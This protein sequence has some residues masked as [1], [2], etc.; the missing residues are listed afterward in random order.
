MSDRHA[1]DMFLS[2]EREENMTIAETTS[3]KVSGKQE[4][5]C[6]VFLGIPFA[7][8]PIG[9]L[10][11][12][13]PIP[14]DPWDGVR[15]CVSF[16]S[17]SPQPGNPTFAD[18]RV[19]MDEDCLTLNVFTPACDGKKRPVAIW[20]H[21][22][23][24][25]T[26]SA[27]ETGLFPHQICVEQDV[28]N[29][30]IQYRLGALGCV[31]F[32]RLSGSG[33][34]FDANCGTWDQVM[35]VEWVIAN[36]ENFGGDPKN[37][38]LMGGSAGGTSVLTLITTPYLKGKIRRA[39]MESTSFYMGLTEENG[40]LA[41]LSVLNELGLKE[42]EVQK[43]LDIPAD[44]LAQAANDAEYKYLSYRPYTIPTGPV[45]DGDLVPEL[46]FDALMRGAADGIDVL[47][48]STADEGSLFTNTKLGLPLLFPVR[49]EDLNKF[50]ADHPKAKKEK[51]LALYPDY[52]ANHAFQEIA[53]E[54]FYHV[55]ILR[56]AE[57]LA[58]RGGNVYV[59]YITYTT[60][61]LRE[62]S[63]GA[64]HCINT[65]MLAGNVEEMLP[66]P[67]AKEQ[68]TA[69]A[70]QLQAQWGNF[71]RTGNP[72]V[73]GYPDWPPYGE[74]KN[75]YFIDVTS[76][77]KQHPFTEIVEAYG[78]IRPYGN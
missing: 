74:E 64:A 65:S 45:V 54:I 33:G 19:T 16:G 35:A 67:S 41:A 9:A 60:P 42:D 55:G 43:I 5:G 77:V 44:R 72:S 8:P 40:R 31:D 30:T 4:K 14:P 22:G 47:V 7:K 76:C 37:I 2:V 78:D 51:I 26:G 34:R 58:E 27:C 49:E 63:L 50:F 46:P 23:A 17:V 10:R 3:G 25:L 38:T 28:V 11:F 21:G 56:A 29:V 36:I 24:Y 75:T 71:F 52:P 48:G 15:E 13:R 18:E 32:S 12:R 59:Y 73:A 1:P 62:I 57:C 53:K 66:D 68:N 69:F 39:V 61:M 70:K 6:E 20:I